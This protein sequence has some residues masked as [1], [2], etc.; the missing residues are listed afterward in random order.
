MCEEQRAGEGMGRT[1][2]MKDPLLFLRLAGSG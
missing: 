1:P 2:G